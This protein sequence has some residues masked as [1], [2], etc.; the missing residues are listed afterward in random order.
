MR[1]E[2]LF[3]RVNHI[4]FLFHTRMDNKFNFHSSRAEGKYFSYFQ[5]HAAPACTQRVAGIVNFAKF[6]FHFS[7]LPQDSHE[8][9]RSKHYPNLS[10]FYILFDFVAKLFNSLFF[11][12][13]IHPQAASL[14]LNSSKFE[15]YFSTRLHQRCHS[16]APKAI[17]IVETRS[18]FH[19]FSIIAHSSSPSL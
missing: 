11:S 5:Q 18:N 9:M 17:R 4:E 13:S 16:M 7:A 8:I 6:L 14:G 3:Y 12:F 19:I 10:N 15:I 1:H 2:I